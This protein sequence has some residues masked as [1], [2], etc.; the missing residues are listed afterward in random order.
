MYL[1]VYLIYGISIVTNNYMY[2][3]IFDF[4]EK[5]RENVILL[6]FFCILDAK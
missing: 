5:E 2:P 3:V 6:T 4:D 1:I